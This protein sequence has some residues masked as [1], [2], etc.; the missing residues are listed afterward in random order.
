MSMC[1]CVQAVVTMVDAACGVIDFKTTSEER[2]EIAMRLVPFIPPLVSL[3]SKSAAAAVL[4]TVIL[5]ALLDRQVQQPFRGRMFDVV[6][7]NIGEVM[8][9][10]IEV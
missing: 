10:Y 9:L 3:N 7:D 1:L 8:R 5:D 4:C 2:Y 6:D